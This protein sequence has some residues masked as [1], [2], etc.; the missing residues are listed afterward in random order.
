[1]VAT[2]TVYFHPARSQGSMHK[3]G[4]LASLAVLYAVII[5]LIS[6][7]IS[8]SLASQDLVILAHI[9]VLF[10]FCGGGLGLV[11]WVK[12]RLKDPL[13]NVACS[14]ASLTIITVL[15]REDFVHIG[16]FDSRSL[17]QVV[18]MLVVAI[19]IST[20][21][22][23]AIRPKYARDELREQM[24]R[25]TDAFAD[26][27]TSITRAF[28]NGSEAE[29]RASAHVAGSRDFKTLLSTLSSTLEDAKFEAYL[30]GKEREFDIERRLVN[31][32]QTIAQSLGG[33]RSAAETQFALLRQPPPLGGATPI[34]M[35]GSNSYF[36]QTDS[37][38]ANGAAILAGVLSP[39]Y[40]SEREL[41]SN[42]ATPGSQTGSPAALSSNP[43]QIF[44]R[45]TMS[46]GPSMVRIQWP[47]H[48]LHANVFLEITRLDDQTNSGRSSVWTWS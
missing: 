48:T 23:F 4:I 38:G 21:V 14:L 18:F 29:L 3:G 22:C 43:S 27:F 33:L 17:R 28:L 8:A 32:M 2:I 25:A 9:L 7:S 11:G 26:A 31:C 46:L 39:I 42:A 45:F 41:Q 5:S 44:E 30:V 34:Q 36:P 24:I 40:E 10:I 37:L 35:S 19:A 1:L 13:V 16:V 15:T 47:F 6:M 12:Q 20:L